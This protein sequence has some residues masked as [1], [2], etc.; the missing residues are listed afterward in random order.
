MRRFRHSPRGE[1]VFFG[2]SSARLIHWFVTSAVI[3]ALG[4]AAAVVFT[5]CNGGGRADRPEFTVDPDA[6]GPTYRNTTLGIEFAPPADWI[7]VDERQRQAVVDA[8]SGDSADETYDLGI[9]DIFFSTD[10]LSFAS[11]FAPTRADG[12]PADYATYVATFTERIGA[13]RDSD[14]DQGQATVDELEVNGIPV[15]LF[16]YLESD[17]IV[18]TLC[19]VASGESVVRLDYS[20]PTS[21]YQ[22]DG[23]KLESS[24]G[25]LRAL[26]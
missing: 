4:A 14:P 18:L 13:V 8:L 6:I 25:T 1:G 2:A 16:R 15:T 19:F 20:I 11:L 21:A 12:S 17:L 7:V 10:T 23:S 26:D 3:A 22:F 5:G 9:V 24:I